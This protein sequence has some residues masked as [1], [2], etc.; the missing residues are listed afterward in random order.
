QRVTPYGGTVFELQRDALVL[1]RE[2][3]AAR[4]KMQRVRL[5]AAQRAD[6]HVEQIRAVDGEVRRAIALDGDRAEVEQ[7]P[8]LAG[9]PM[10]DFLALRLARQG[11]ELLA[12]A[13]RV[14]HARA[15]RRELHA[16]ADFLQLR[17]LLVDIDVDA[18]LE[19]R[20]R[21]AQ[22]ADAAAG[23]QNAHGAQ[24]YFSA[25]E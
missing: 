7:L 2:A 9:L 14:E 17:S 3:A 10:A 23:D 8:G 16:G 15:V 22:P 19:Q 11:L 25:C 13:K 6:D 20:Q 4:A 12:D 21:G 5:G 18:V 1:L 24:L